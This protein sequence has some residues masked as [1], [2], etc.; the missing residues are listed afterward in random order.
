[1][2]TLVAWLAG[3][4]EA[5]IDTV[6]EGALAL[7]GDQAIEP[8]RLDGANTQLGAFGQARFRGPHGQ[9]ALLDAVI[10]EELLVQEARDAGYGE[11]HP[12]VE[13]AVLEELAELQR[14]AMLE[15]RLPRAE[16]AADTE[17]LR[18]RY[19]RERD[20]K[21]FEPERR[22]IEAV[23]FPTFEEAE[24]ALARLKSGEVDIAG[25]AAEQGRD[26]LSSPA[27]KRDD[28]E[29]PRYHE[30]L[31]DPELKVGEPLS[32]PV[33]SDKLVL[34]AVLA[35]IV[36]RSHVPFDTPEVQE[37]LVSAERAARLE[38]VEAE[39]LDELRAQYP[40]G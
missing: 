15:R 12:L 33:L 7:V 38:P 40:A 36:P 6:P 34:V 2:A 23:Y 8:E 16:V 17:A 9:R 11:A 21:F 31:F 27:M 29:F 10:D 14:A 24:G 35:E 32:E 37:Q 5:Q 28:D 39:L 18:A 25:V 22:R 19:E 1:M 3:A 26:V 13:W 20:E 30:V 4:C